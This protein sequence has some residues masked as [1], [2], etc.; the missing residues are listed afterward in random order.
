MKN[1]VAEIAKNDN[2]PEN[3]IILR[4]CQNAALLDLYDKALARKD[5]KGNE[6][7]EL[8]DSRRVVMDRICDTS[9]KYTPFKLTTG[10]SLH[11][12]AEVTQ[13]ETKAATLT[14]EITDS[15][16]I[17]PKSPLELVKDQ[18]ILKISCEKGLTFSTPQFNPP[19]AASAGA[20]HVNDILGDVKTVHGL[21]AVAEN[22]LINW[23]PGDIPKFTAQSSAEM[24]VLLMQLYKLVSEMK[25]QDPS[26]ENFPLEKMVLQVPSL[27]YYHITQL[28]TDFVSAINAKLYI[29]DPE[30]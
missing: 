28:K 24:K 29:S 1:V 23:K 3:T 15:F 2:S 8:Q 14:D 10:F 19:T 25:K 26:F 20:P 27:Q 9:T 22:Y 17:D 6:S 18:G 12:L 30:F 11:R 5:I 7:K 21:H 4:Q 13:N 16:V